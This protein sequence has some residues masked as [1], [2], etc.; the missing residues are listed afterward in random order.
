MSITIGT[1]NILHPPYA[2]RHKQKEGLNQNGKHNWH[3]RKDRI[4]NLIKQ[5]DLDVL[6]LQEIGSR[7]NLDL[8]EKLRNAYEVV[9]VSRERGDGLAIYFKKGKFEKIKFTDLGDGICFIDLNDRTMGKVVRVANCH[10]QGGSQQNVGKQQIETLLA[11]VNTP[12]S[13]PIA[14]RIIAGDFNSDETQLHQAD[15]KFAA[16]HKAGFQ[17]NGDLSETELPKGGHAKGRH[18]DWI[19]SHSDTPGLIPKPHLIAQSEVVSDHL[20][21]ASKIPTEEPAKP[22]SQTIAKPI[23]PLPKDQWI[24]TQLLQYIMRYMI[25]LWSLCYVRKSQ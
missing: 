18:I 16:L 9:H 14:V 24:C 6:C 7:S 17:H 23:A 1:L 3:T 5:S 25:M 15:S 20:L 19:W 2:E 4:A 22:V 11:K 21:S 8:Q 10:L 12:S 13:T